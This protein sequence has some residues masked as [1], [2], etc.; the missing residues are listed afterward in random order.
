[1]KQPRPAP[2]AAPKPE[3]MSELRVSGHLMRLDPGLFCVVQMP[4]PGADP[5]SG[6]PGVRLSLPPGPN[7][8]PESVRL[9]GFHADGWLSGTGDAALVR[10]LGEPAQILVTIYQARDAAEGTAPNL[11]V[12]RLFDGQ[13]LPVGPNAAAP[14]AAAPNVAAPNV[15][16]LGAGAP[17]PVA[18][19]PAGAAGPGIAAPPA[20]AA[21]P[22]RVM[23]MVA[24]I[25]ERG[26]VGAMFGE[27]VGERDSKRWIEGFGLAPANG[28]PPG[29]IEY[30][31]VLGPGWLS[32]WVEGGQFCGS[33]GMALPLLGLRVRL[34]GATAATHEVS[35][36][37]S[38]V[39]GSQVGPVGNGEPCETAGL[40]AIES[41]R[42]ELRPRSAVTSPAPSSP[43]PSS[44]GPVAVAAEPVAP[45]PARPP[46]AAAAPVR[47]MAAQAA[48]VKAAP[49]R[50]A[51]VKAASVRAAP[52]KAAGLRAAGS[53]PAASRAAPIQPATGKPAAGAVRA[54]R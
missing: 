35:Y 54:K 51:P 53:R 12:R 17:V 13:G 7:G 30:Q 19:R 46:R 1:M 3:I 4:T 8:R 39:D 48:T 25:Q 43:G 34:R 24:H 44:P 29:D 14:N 42:V 26:D 50:A 41:F 32:P 45:R 10:V 36:A 37:A 21:G 23:E 40:A 47:R 28:I 27:W 22:R 15:A 11:Q 18:P 16:A 9:S 6:L 20:V 38:F 52:V 31:A 2:S 5:V 33:R 49:V